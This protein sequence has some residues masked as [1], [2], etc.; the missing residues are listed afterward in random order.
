MKEIFPHKNKGDFL[1]ADHVNRLSEVARRFAEGRPASG[2]YGQDGTAIGPGEFHQKVVEVDSGNDD[3]TYEI[4]LRYYDVD[5]ED[6]ERDD[7]QTYTIDP[8]SVG[9]DLQIGQVLSAWWHNQRGMY[10]PLVG[11]GS[12]A[13]RVHFVI[14]SYDDSTCLATCLPLARPCGSIAVAGEV[15]GHITVVDIAG[16]YFNEL[17]DDL[18]GRIGHADWLQL[19]CD[20]YVNS[21]ALDFLDSLNTDPYGRTMPCSLDSL[22]ALNNGCAWVVSGLCCPPL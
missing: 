6:W 15:D 14:E 17:P 8:T 1:T 2:L 12:P 9:V 4:W 5:T 11:G 19:E 18:V 21:E 16:C 13:Q 20:D 7:R 22:C 3:G 10:I